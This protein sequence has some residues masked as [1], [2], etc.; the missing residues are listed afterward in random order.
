LFTIVLLVQ[1]FV[2]LIDEWRRLTELN[3]VLESAIIAGQ[4]QQVSR[5]HF[6]NLSQSSQ[7]GSKEDREP[8]E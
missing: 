6:R 4:L 3:K 7:V 8:E 1:L 2:D 5:S